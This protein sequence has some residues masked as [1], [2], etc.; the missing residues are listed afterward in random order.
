MTISHVERLCGIGLN[1][2]MILNNT[3]VNITNEIAA[4]Y[5]KMVSL[6]LAGRN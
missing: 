2:M 1:G 5:V 3:Y 4:A 6:N